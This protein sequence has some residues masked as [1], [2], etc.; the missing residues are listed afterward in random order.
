MYNTSLFVPLLLAFGLTACGTELAA[1]PLPTVVL[2]AN[3]EVSSAASGGS[4][5]ASGEVVPEPKAELS[6]PLT[7]TVK[8]VAVEAGDKVTKGQTLVTL[9]P[10]LW[11][12]LVQEAEGDLAS[13]EAEER[14]RVRIGDD[15]EHIDAA[16]A[17]VDRARAALDAAHATLNQATLTAPFEGSI[18]S[19]DISRAES[20]TPG[21]QVVLIGDLDHFQVVTTDL[22]ERDVPTIRPGQ[23]ASIS[24]TALGAE[25]PG[26]VSDIARVPSTVGGDVV[27][28]VT[29]RFDQQPPGLLWGMTVEVRIQTGS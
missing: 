23:P 2:G 5:A 9:D 25:F 19:V 1:T 26:T 10:T 4:V 11:E 28:E 16:N 21:E 3:P 15:Q 7:G 6:F 27:Y 20:V 13:A 29:L 17:D 12:A 18:A 22:S 8:I 24:V 14:Y